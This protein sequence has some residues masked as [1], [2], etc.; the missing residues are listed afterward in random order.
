MWGGPRHVPVRADERREFLAAAL[1]EAGGD[2]LTARLA[3][4]QIIAVQQTLAVENTRQI[5]AGRA[6]VD[7]YPEA[8]RAAERGFDLLSG[9]IPAPYA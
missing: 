5:A 3:A 7:V 4:T 8:A 2:D 1:R 6:A 9:G